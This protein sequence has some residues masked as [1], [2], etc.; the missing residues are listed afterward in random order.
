MNTAPLTM[1][2]MARRNDKPMRTQRMVQMLRITRRR[3]SQSGGGPDG[4]REP[5]DGSRK[6]SIA[7]V[8]RGAGYL[9]ILTA[10]AMTSAASISESA[11]CTSIVSFAQCDSGMTSVGLNAVAFV[12][13]V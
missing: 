13:D 5:F 6:S 11:D 3:D 10:R 7:T 12:N 8:S 2:A 9:R 4:G 1:S